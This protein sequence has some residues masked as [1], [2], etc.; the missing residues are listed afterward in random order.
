MSV[1][2][3][4]LVGSLVWHS[5]PVDWC[6]GNYAIISSI[7]EFYNTFSNIIF[8][9]MPP[10]LMY[11]FRDYARKVHP[12]IHIVWGL[13]IFVGLASAYFHAT[14]SLMGQLLDELSILW[15]YSLTMAL[16][17]PRRNLPKVFK[18]RIVFSA[19]LLFISIFAS[20]LSVWRP[21]VNAFALMTLIIPTVYLLCCELDR[22]KHKDPEVFSLGIRS[23]V[24]MICA[25]TI[26]FND[27]MFCDFYTSMQITYL[28]AIWHVAIFLSSYTCCVLF[29]YF[30]VQLERPKIHCKLAYFPENTLISAFGI[31]YVDFKQRKSI[32]D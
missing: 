17:C 13:L 32:H 28:H 29:A 4:G 6:E 12:G 14:L 19:L 18:N 15:V 3:A 21:Y 5:S 26:W 7:A 1:G 11:L 2:E 20:I 24:L 16:F 31:P 25:V 23:L 10:I 30:Y 27:R 8:I 9:I 22:V